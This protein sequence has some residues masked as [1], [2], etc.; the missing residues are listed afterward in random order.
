MKRRGA[1]YAVALSRDMND[2]RKEAGSLWLSMPWCL[3]VP[4]RC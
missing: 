2:L 3:P 1:S 4:H